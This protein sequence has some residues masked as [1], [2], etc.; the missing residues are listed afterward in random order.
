M[1]PP[2]I[3]EAV[4]RTGAAWKEPKN[5]K[6]LT[7]ETGGIL[8]SQWAE[9]RVGVAAEAGAAGDADAGRLI[10]QAI[11]D[12]P[13]YQGTCCLAGIQLRLRNCTRWDWL[14]EVFIDY[15]VTNET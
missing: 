7:Q 10:H 1:K 3:S 8:L 4:L 11:Y 6:Y 14:T 9:A 5:P 2:C 13:D 15:N 12:T